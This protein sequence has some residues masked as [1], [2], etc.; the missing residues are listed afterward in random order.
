MGATR[1][2]RKSTVIVGTVAAVLIAVTSSAS[3]A[4]RPDGPPGLT[5]HRQAESEEAGETE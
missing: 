1:R 4:P 3:G 5:K 2:P